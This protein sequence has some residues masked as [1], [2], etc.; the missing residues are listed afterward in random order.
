MVRGDV[1]RNAV[2]RILMVFEILDQDEG[3]RECDV[4]EELSYILVAVDIHGPV[5]DIDKHLAEAVTRLHSRH[6]RELKRLDPES[7]LCRK[8]H[9]AL[10]RGVREGQE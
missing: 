9:K 10:F 1:D 8:L 5:V 2:E 6:M 7:S 4:E 3:G